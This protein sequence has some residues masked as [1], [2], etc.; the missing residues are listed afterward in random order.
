[1]GWVA[2]SPHGIN[3]T[4]PLHRVMAMCVSG[5]TLYAAADSPDLGTEIWKAS[6]GDERWMPV[7]SFRAMRTAETMALHGG[8]LYIGGLDNSARA[9]LVRIT[10]D[11]PPV[12]MPLDG[13]YGSVTGLTS[14][15]LL[16][17][18][19]YLLLSLDGTIWRATMPVIGSE[20]WEQIGAP[21]HALG[22]SHRYK[23]RPHVVGIKLARGSVAG[24]ILAGTARQNP[25]AA[26]GTGQGADVWRGNNYGSTWELLAKDG[27]GDPES[28]GL[29]HSGG[30]GNIGAIPA[31]ASFRDVWGGV[32]IY[33]SAQNHPDGST[34]YKRVASRRWEAQPYRLSPIPPPIRSMASFESRL[35]IAEGAVAAEGAD[36][37]GARL[38][39]TMSGFG[40][41]EDRYDFTGSGGETPYYLHALTPAYA[42]SQRF[43]Y[44][45]VEYL[46]PTGV[47]IWRRNLDLSDSVVTTIYQAMRMALPPQ[48]RLPLPFRP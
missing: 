4:A 32:H 41:G 18:E 21:H 2:V 8:A 19:P 17:M 23:G 5:S 44:V 3:P 35:F 11:D 14:Q 45:A 39:Y 36:S 9:M 1:M 46:L 12:I 42:G 25:G 27:F 31:L 6:V 48:W 37:H 43:L 22:P 20:H 38:F 24:Q 47:K 40:W 7:S 30:N 28:P 26:G 29:G 10:L 15:D 16:S 13:P 33:A 34:V